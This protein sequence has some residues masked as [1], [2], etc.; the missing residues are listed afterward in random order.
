VESGV[1]KRK[2]LRSNMSA[3]KGEKM[4]TTNHQPIR[5]LTLKL[6][7]LLPL[8]LVFATAA[9]AQTA[10]SNIFELD[11]DSVAGSTYGVSN[12]INC[13]WNTLNGAKT[14]NSISPAGTCAGGGA[15]FGAYGFLVGAPGEPNFSTGG[16]KDG[17]DITQWA[18]TSTSTPDKDTLTHG[19]A[20]S[21]TGSVSQNSDN[22]L[23]FGAERFSV[24]GDSNIGIWFFQNAV[25]TTGGSKG[26]FNGTHVKGDILVLSAFSGGGGTSRV[27]FRR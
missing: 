21:Y 12:S 7:F 4:R 10:P 22:L 1:F 20:A 2:E 15:S 5:G 18:F 13:D 6:I 8:A 17:L 24:S 25:S 9:M 23:V 11:G 26:T 16:S 27:R 3:K 14:A 19:Y